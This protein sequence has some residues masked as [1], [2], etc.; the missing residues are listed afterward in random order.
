M[1]FVLNCVLLRLLKGK[2]V[3]T[4][5]ERKTQT[6]DGGRVV[7]VREIYKIFVLNPVGRSVYKNMRII[8]NWVLKYVIKTCVLD[9]FGSEQGPVAGCCC[10]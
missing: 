5:I 4:T 2:S 6:V 8:L 3:I 7:Q 9:L 10:E 1:I